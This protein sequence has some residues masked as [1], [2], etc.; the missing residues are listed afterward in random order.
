MVN[1]NPIANRAFTQRHGVTLRGVIVGFITLQLSVLAGCTT[2]TNQNI[3]TPDYDVAFSCVNGENLRVR[4][5]TEQ[6]VA[7]L[8]RNSD[9]IKLFQQ[10][11]GSGF[12]YSNGPKTIRG[13][14]DNLTVE[15]GRMMPIECVKQ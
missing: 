13:K 5:Y 7:V 8:L 11:S 15:I 1:I 6:E 14:G 3:S 12:I 9:E 10:K 4:F 2:T